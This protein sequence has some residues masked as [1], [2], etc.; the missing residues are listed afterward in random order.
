VS[1]ATKDVGRL[2]MAQD[3]GYRVMAPCQTRLPTSAL[4]GRDA[5]CGTPQ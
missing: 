3:T 1:T 2:S 4:P 5:Q